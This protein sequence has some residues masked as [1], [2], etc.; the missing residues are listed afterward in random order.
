M[1]GEVS[2]PHTKGKFLYGNYYGFPM[3]K[4]KQIPED[5]IVR[6]MSN[7]TINEN[8]GSYLY[9]KLKKKN[10]NTL[11]AIKQVAR[12]LHIREKDIG[13]A[14]SKDKQ[15]VTEQIISIAVNGR[16]NKVNKEKI[17]RINL[18]NVRFE[19]LGYGKSP[20]SLGDLK[21]NQFEI[22]VRNLDNETIVEEVSFATNYFD[23]QRFSLHNAAIGKHLVKKEFKEALK[24]ID[25]N[26]SNEHLELKP[27]DCIGAL[28]KIP[29][30][31]LRIYI[32]AYQS[33]IWNETVARL[34]IDRFNIVKEVE[35]SLGEFV[36]VE[37][38][39]G[40][41]G[42]SDLSVALIGFNQDLVNNSEAKVI[43]NELMEAEKLTHQDFIIKQ[44]PEL[45]L[46]GEMRKV[47]VPV[48]NLIVGQ[49]QEDELNP[50]K[51]KVEVSFT[52]PKGSYATI[53]VKKMFS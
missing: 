25:N 42:Y 32:N 44:I 13:F 36:F 8:Q 11:D 15:A 48:K 27:N 29:L 22:V 5:F 7:I 12:V 3:Y 6:E 50:G 21:G 28:K 24:L 4:L 16:F 33:Y 14:G 43:I 10:R 20:I 39:N 49:F 1:C 19:F 34:L 46:E 47:F 52:L 38:D 2:H 41:K 30:R 37:E 31:L 51:M 23:E 18:E 17:L 53:V 35:Y 9:F 26:S 40:Q 45:S